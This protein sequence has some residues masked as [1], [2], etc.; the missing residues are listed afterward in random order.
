[1]DRIVAADHDG[2]R[3]AVESTCFCEKSTHGASHHAQL[4]GSYTL[5]AVTAVEPQVHGPQPNARLVPVRH[6]M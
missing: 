4:N 6:S 5:T 2:E 1:M 3:K